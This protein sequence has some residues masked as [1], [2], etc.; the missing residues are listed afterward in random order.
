MPVHNKGNI[1]AAN[2]HCNTEHLSPM[3]IASDLQ[4]KFSDSVSS[5]AIYNQAC[6][7]VV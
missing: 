2:R 5:S 7:F 1:S 6:I 3:T 4:T